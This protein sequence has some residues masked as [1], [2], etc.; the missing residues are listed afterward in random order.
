MFQETQLEF[1]TVHL[2]SEEQFIIYNTD[3]N[4]KKRPIYLALSLIW[5]GRW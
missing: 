3:L 5:K 2:Q 4:V 1:E